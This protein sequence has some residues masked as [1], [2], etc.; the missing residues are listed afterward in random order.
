M[1]C[2]ILLDYKV[3]IHYIFYVIITNISNIKMQNINNIRS[4]F[5][6]FFKQNN[7]NIISSSSLVPSND[8][9]LMFTNAGMV[10]FKNFFTGVEK[11]AY[12]RAATSQ[13]CVRA[14]GKHNDLD[15]V[16]F[17]ARH[18]TFFEMLGNFS[19]GDYFKEEAI[20]LAW[21]FITEEL[22]LDK[23]RLYF[24]VFESDDEAYNLWQKISGASSDRIIRIATNDNFWSMGDTGPCGP[25]SEIFYDHGEHIFGGLPGTKDQDGDRFTEIWNLVFMQYEQLLDSRIN[26]PKPSIDTGMWLERIAAVVQN[27]H[28]NYDTDLF[29]S[30][31]GNTESITKVKQTPENISS[32]RIIADHLRAI[33]FLIADGVMPAN[34][35]RGYVLRRIMRRAMR[36]AHNLGA[37][38]PLM[39]LLVPALIEEMGEAYPELVR[40]KS[41]TTN[42]LEQ[43]EI[44]FRETLDKGLKLLDLELNTLGEG[45]VLK[46][47][48]AF[49]LY[50]T[51]GFPLDLTRDILRSKDKTI[52][53]AEF[54]QNMQ[55]Q[56]VKARAAWAGSG[57]EATNKLW[58]ELTDVF[59]KTEF[60]GYNLTKAKGKVIAIV[61][62]NNIVASYDGADEFMLITN[63]T[64]FY[65]ESGGQIGDIGVI[66]NDKVALQVIN[67]KKYLDLHIH[68]VRLTN[69]TIN[70][71]DELNLE[72]DIVYRNK[73]RS[74]HSATHILHAVLREVLGNHV[75]QKGSLV[76]HDRL[77]FDISHPKAITAME[78]NL[79]EEKV[80][81]VIRSNRSANT[82]LMDSEA[83]IKA[84]AMALFG[85]KYAE[86]VRVVKLGDSIELCGGLHVNSTG[87]IGMFKIVTESAIA[88][89]IRRIEA[90]T[91]YDAILYIQNH[92][93]ILSQISEIL[94]S[95]LNDIPEKINQI[96]DER[97]KLQK[98]LTEFKSSSINF[99][100]LQ[101]NASIINSINFIYKLIDD[102]DPKQ[103]RG[104]AE[105]LK[106]QAVNTIIVL[107]TVSCGKVSLII[108]VSDGLTAKYQAC[109]LAKVASMVLNGNGGGRDDLAQAGGPEI[110]KIDDSI[111]AIK[112]FIKKIK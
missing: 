7:H 94:K 104:A 95:T 64:P 4:S 111:A 82:V 23:Q 20:L 28:N 85:E 73:I 6:N 107:A 75:V 58:Y 102:I 69:G 62:D 52:D 32:Y 15:N 9:T 71:D 46:G 66:C 56:K 42:I 10:Q 89:G 78:L 44:K 30:I 35:G 31:I 65:G 2:V 8:P 50:D 19:F 53:E 51:Y 70:K 59:G 16:G 112:D 98:Q 60:L 1:T 72:V 87:D 81:A 83:A 84:G 33:S 41:L 74:N 55:E 43:E 97:R 93:K 11:P 61:K 92:E 27:V 99:D 91:G 100:D 48:V 106:K 57:E 80:N 90:V 3:I 88:S 34:D 24:T 39:H 77:R 45:K 101:R 103:L 36:H 21:K 38:E 47:S 105:N 109:E 29:K 18:H 37:R 22:A 25:C 63:Q 108:T 12:N 76:A 86:E 54:D 17:T 67:T 68:I 79:I 49:K 14:G 5:L 110:S 26:L 40:A 13:K 96:L